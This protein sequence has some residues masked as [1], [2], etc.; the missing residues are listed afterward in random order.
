M[1]KEIKNFPNYYITENGDV[2]SR[3]N[4]LCVIKKLNLIKDRNGYLRVWFRTPK[5][6]SC[7]VHRLVAETF[8]PNPNNKP[9]VNHKNGIRDDNYFENLEWCSKSENILH[10]FRIL[11]RNK[12]RTVKPVQQ[13]LNNKIIAEFSSVNEAYRLTGINRDSI[14]NSCRSKEGYFIAGGF[15]WKYK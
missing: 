8:I 13:I 1:M 10:A 15:H 4:K 2:Y 14:Y 11:K 3:K 7:L 9:E 12:K 6:I 5:H